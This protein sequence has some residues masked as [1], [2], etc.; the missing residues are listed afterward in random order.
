[1]PS[2]TPNGRGLGYRRD[3]HRPKLL[4]LA[5]RVDRVVVTPPY[6]DLRPH[7]LPII[8]Q[9]SYGTCTACACCA[10]FEYELLR[11]HVPVPHNK[12]RLF[13]YYNAGLKEGNGEEHKDDGR[14]P[15]YNFA[16]MAADG[17]C[18]EL[19]WPYTP[20]RTIFTKPSSIA[21]TAATHRK[22]LNWL[23]IPDDVAQLKQALAQGYSVGIAIAVWESFESSTVA[24]TGIV[25]LPA[26]GEQLLGGHMLV[27]VGYSD[28]ALAGVPAEHLIVRNSWGIGF[29]DHGYV[30]LPYE[31]I[32]ATG[33][34]GQPLT[35][36]M[37]AL[38]MITGPH[39]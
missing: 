31:W 6:V 11:Q 16:S 9:G 14:D 23:F 10:M 13:S 37:L 15:H 5:E 4:T 25:P 28:T 8:D 21:Y 32:N 34:D 3:P 18:D 24:T 20:E 22:A 39:P 12:S 17:L 1:M 19:L 29:G 33:N 38:E 2:T 26:P 7:F 36:D 30:Y 35:W 27:V